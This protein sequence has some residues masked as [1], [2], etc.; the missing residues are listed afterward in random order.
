[1]NVTFTTN[2]PPRCACARLRDAGC[3]VRFDDEFP[4]MRRFYSQDPHGNR[5]EFLEPLSA[6]GPQGPG[7]DAHQGS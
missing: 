7:P 2:G 5:L 3:P 6:P 4:G 1:M